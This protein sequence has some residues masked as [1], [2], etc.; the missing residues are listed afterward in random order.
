[1]R[2]IVLAAMPSPL[3]GISTYSPS[4]MGKINA[5]TGPQP[6]AQDSKSST[7]ETVARGDA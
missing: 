5:I 4:A 1:V 7:R 3:L 2:R 6:Q